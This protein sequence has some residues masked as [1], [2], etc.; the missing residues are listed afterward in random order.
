[1]NTWKESGKVCT[2]YVRVLLTKKIIMNHNRP[3]EDELLLFNTQ[4][5]LVIN[6]FL[7]ADLV[8]TLLICL[9]NTIRERKKDDFDG[10]FR[11]ETL[12]SHGITNI[13]G[14]N[15]RIFHILNDNELFLDMLDYPPLMPYLYSFLSETPHFHA[16]DAIW[17]LEPGRDNPEWHRD[18]VGDGFSTF[19]PNIPLLQIKVG[20]LLSDMTKPDQ[21]NLTLVPGSHTTTLDLT[22]T[23]KARFDSLPGAI[24]ICEPAGTMI[25]FHNAIWHTSGPWRVKEGKRIMLYYAYEHNWMMA[26]PE[27]AFYRGAFYRN[28]SAER[29]Q[30]FHDFVLDLP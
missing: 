21:G 2:T 14:K 11:R 26:S 13:S 6:D 22:D 30:M 20:Y 15:A 25:M 3:T 7:P 23:Q 17:E 24:Q 9:E 1:M 4:G 5:Y 8:S 12:Y 18:G 10:D 28:L 16:S 29:Q 19:S 27:H